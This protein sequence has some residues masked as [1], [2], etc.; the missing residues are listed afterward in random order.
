MIGPRLT[1][2]GKLLHGIAVG[3]AAAAIEQAL[4]G[5]D[6]VLLDYR[7]PDGDGLAVLRALKASWDP[8][9]ILNPGKLGG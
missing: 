3:T 9:G 4:S 5:V 1:K 7:L 2:P 8:R 6:L